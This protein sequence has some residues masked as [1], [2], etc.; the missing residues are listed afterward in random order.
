[1]TADHVV[2]HASF[3]GLRED[4][5]AKEVVVEEPVPLSGPPGSA[6]EISSRG[7]VIFPGDG[8]TKGDLADYYRAAA[9]ILLPWLA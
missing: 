8:L 9:P 7:R 3:L 6:V 5:P 2:R 1:F 4:K